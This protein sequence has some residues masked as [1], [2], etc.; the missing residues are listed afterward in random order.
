[1]GS[2]STRY[3]PE[4]AT[5][6]MPSRAVSDRLICG[7]S[8]SLMSRPYVRDMAIPPTALGIIFVQV[9]VDRKLRDLLSCDRQ[10][11]IWVL[12]QLRQHLSDKLHLSRLVQVSVSGMEILCEHSST[13]SPCL[14]I[15][16]SGNGPFPTHPDHEATSERHNLEEVCDMART[17]H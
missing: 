10:K 1:M 11:A 8:V 7:S 9:E 4:P 12:Q 14:S 6:E 3:T 5:S 13:F 15:W 16:Y 2:I 17:V